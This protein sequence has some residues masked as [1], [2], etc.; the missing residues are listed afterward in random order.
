MRLLVVEDDDEVGDALVDVLHELGFQVERKARGADLLTGH[1]RYDAAVLDLGLADGDGLQ[2]LGKLREIST[3]PVVVLSARD[4]DRTIVRA[5]RVG[6]DDYLV[7]PPR[8]GELAARLE[9]VTRRAAAAPPDQPA[10]VVA[11]DVRIDL[12]ARRIH[13]GGE[14]VSVTG[15]EFDLV[16][17]LVERPGSAVSREVLMERVWGGAIAAVSQSLDAHIANVR[18]KLGR[19]DLIKTIRGFGYRWGH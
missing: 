4:D 18:V 15:R 5:L 7:K 3:I 6:A 17:A 9:T 11:G 1:S 8:I 2:V 10:V 12:C 14:P 19:P 13:V 16:A